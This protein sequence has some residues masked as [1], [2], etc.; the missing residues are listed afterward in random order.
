[1]GGINDGASDVSALGTVEALLRVTRYTEEFEFL[2]VDSII[3]FFWV[4]LEQTLH[5]NFS[6]QS[7]L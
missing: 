3:V 2:T 7:S 5:T 1:M 4:L 6:G